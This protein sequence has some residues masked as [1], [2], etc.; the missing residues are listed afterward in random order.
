MTFW[1]SGLGLYDRLPFAS[2][3]YYDT[4]IIVEPLPDPC[5]LLFARSTVC[6][7]NDRLSS[8]AVSAVLYS[9][10][11]STPT[12]KS[13]R[14]RSGLLT[15]GPLAWET[16]DALVPMA[17]DLKPPFLCH[18]DWSRLAV[19]ARDRRIISLLRNSRNYLINEISVTLAS[20]CPQSSKT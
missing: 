2:H 10:D 13:G 8:F 5:T 16:A 1:S 4:G 15:V 12:W 11:R 7:L 19:S 20:T 6:G 3:C 14:Q 18:G 9:R 17:N